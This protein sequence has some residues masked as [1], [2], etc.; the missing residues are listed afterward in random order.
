MT[1]SLSPTRPG[2]DFRALPILLGLGFLAP[3]PAAA[4]TVLLTTGERL[5]GHV[6]SDDGG[7]MVFDSDGLGRISVPRERVASVERTVAKEDL[8]APPPEPGSDARAPAQ[9]D[10]TASELPREGP[11]APSEPPAAK[12]EDLLRLWV[13]QG[14]RYQIVQ[15]V[16]IPIPFSDGESRVRDEVRVTGRIGIRA[17]VDVAGFE[18]SRGLPPVESDAVLRTLRFYTTGDWSPTV[19]YALQLGVIDGN[20]YLHQA[21]I[22]WREVPYLH[23]VSFGYLGVQQTLEN[24]LPFGG[25]TFMEPALPVL[26]FAPGNRMGLQTDRSLRDGRGSF[27]FGLYSVGADPG[28]NFGDSTQSLLRPTVRLTALPVLTDAASSGGRTLLHLGLSG[29]V[30]LANESEVRYRARPESFIAP[31]ITD[32]GKIPSRG[33]TFVGTELVWMQGPFTLQSEAML[34]RTAGSDQPHGFWGAYLSAS[35]MLTGEEAGYNTAVGVPDRVIPTRDFSRSGGSWGAWQLGL[36]L[37]HLD[38]SDGDVPGSRVTE[39]T[40]GLNWWWDR[41]LRWQLNY[42]YAVARDGPR[43]GH[44]QVLQARVQLM[45]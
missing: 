18:T 1:C 36:R 15:P 19:S 23:N 13:D 43:P 42:G 21:N 44:L 40:L 31:F 9:P 26:A 25:L 6:V 30:T 35:W 11:A 37:S 2:P 29:S 39:G 41:Y 3:F 5:S 28:L 32:T 34:N 12:R 10:R 27:T 4:D 17:A 16:V 20:P 33:A 8:P 45:Y 24:V 14:L 7:V 38:L 22:R